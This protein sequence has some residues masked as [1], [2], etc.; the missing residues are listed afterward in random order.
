MARIAREAG[1]PE[2]ALVLDETGVTSEATVAAVEGLVRERGWGEVL[3]VSHDAHLA[4]LALLARAQ[5]VTARTVPA[6][7][8]V[9]WRS[10]PVF[11]LREV[12]AFGWHWLRTS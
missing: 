3:L 6:R 5:G 7:E 11:V 10:K 2:A 1:V 8:T 9:A 4:R 12:L